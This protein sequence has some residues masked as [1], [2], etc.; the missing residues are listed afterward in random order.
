MIVSS[1]EKKTTTQDLNKELENTEQDS[2]LFDDEPTKNNNLAQF[3]LGAQMPRYMKMCAAIANKDPEMCKQI[4]E[5]KDAEQRYQRAICV[6]SVA[7]AS[8]DPSICDKYETIVSE[9][10][11][12]V[13]T[14]CKMSA[15]IGSLKISECE[16]LTDE[17]A[18]NGCIY[19]VNFRAGK[20]K[21]S[22]CK[23]SECVFTYT[24]VHKDKA[25]CDMMTEVSTASAMSSSFK[26][27][28]YAMLSGDKTECDPLKSVGVNEWYYCKTKA[29]Y[30]QV[31][32][33]P[34]IYNLDVCEDDSLCYKFALG[35]MATYIASQ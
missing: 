13:D 22:E 26:V 32:P 15:A 1:C 31:M 4:F 8:A 12:Y 10:G 18:R 19:Q 29:Q 20:T 11:T 34:G 27:A 21:V 9:G 17:N 2:G 35:E 25:A 14:S 33:S 6:T 7:T 5:E 16:K 3:C 28:C 24:R 30:K 23:D